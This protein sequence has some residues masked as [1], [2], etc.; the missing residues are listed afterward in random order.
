LH[1]PTGHTINLLV[2]EVCRTLSSL[3]IP[4]QTSV[5]KHS[6]DKSI[7]DA[8]TSSEA[9][10]EEVKAVADELAVVRSV[11]ETRLPEV[12]EEVKLAVERTGDAGEQLD[13]TAEKLDDAHKDL[14]EA[15]GGGDK[16]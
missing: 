1:R 16:A 7:E 9:A 3:S 12:D 2:H 10:A 6:T 5:T 8:L 13:R 15:L 4:L 11:L 14:R